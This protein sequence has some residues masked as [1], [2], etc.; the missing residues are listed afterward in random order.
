MDAEHMELTGELTGIGLRPLVDFLRSLRKSGHFSI[1]DDRWTGTLLLNDGQIVGARFGQDHGLSALDSIF[2]A[3]QHGR[4]DF[5][6]ST[7]CERNIDLSARELD[8]HLDSLEAEIEPLARFVT[9][10]SAIPCRSVAGNDGE[11]TVGRGALRLLLA[12]DGQRTLAEHATERGLLITLR[13][14]AELA[15]LGLV[16][17]EADARPSV[18]P[19]PT[20]FPGTSVP[21]RA[22]SQ[23][24]NA[25]GQQIQT[26][27]PQPNRHAA[28]RRLKIPANPPR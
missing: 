9:S 7:D 11:L 4:F 19:E 22:A 8:D 27:N 5:V 1:R 2:F 12:L 17:F 3:L 13:E 15:H 21:S 20:A 28:W 18:R 24:L 26:A 6:T 14:I 23:G 16:T 25:G 10:M